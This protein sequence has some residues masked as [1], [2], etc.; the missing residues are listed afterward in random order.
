VRKLRYIAPAVAATAGAAMALG[1]ALPA[2]ANTKSK[3]CD[4]YQLCL[5][6][7]HGTNSPIFETN[8]NHIANLE[9]YDFA[10]TDL[11]VRNDAHS[12][13]TQRYGDGGAFFD[14]LWVYPNYSGTTA[15]SLS[16]SSTTAYNQ[17]NTLVG[18]IINNEASYFDSQY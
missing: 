1:P 14:Y 8:A 13:A 3:S 10:G 15:Y 6:Y 17:A 9:D 2:S 4:A 16:Y 12:G 18:G 11:I 7:S 5:W